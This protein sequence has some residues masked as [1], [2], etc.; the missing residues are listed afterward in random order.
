MKAQ[1][2]R[3]VAINEPAARRLILPRG[4]PALSRQGT[5]LRSSALTRADLVT[6]EP[7]SL[8]PGRRSRSS[9]DV[10]SPL[11]IPIQ[12]PDAVR[13]LQLEHGAIGK[14]SRSPTAVPSS[15][16]G[17]TTSAR[18][19]TPSA[20]GGSSDPF[21]GRSPVPRSYPLPKPTSAASTRPAVSCANSASQTSSSRW[22]VDTNWRMPN[23][24][25]P[26]QGRL[27][28]PCSLTHSTECCTSE[29]GSPA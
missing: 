9:H 23:G 16:I 26:E 7:P 18:S 24:R 12:G 3:V 11:S 2:A 5:P 17:S 21:D 15:S 13:H 4:L 10:Q 20:T 19:S 14:R 8:N 6:G 1:H 28:P 25:A 22:R 29:H 27:R